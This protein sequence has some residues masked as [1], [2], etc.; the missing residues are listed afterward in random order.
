[1]RNM[2]RHL[3][4][5]AAAV[6]LA[7]PAAAYAD[8]GTETVVVTGMRAESEA[9]GIY[10]VK[11]ADH[12]ITNVT[13]VC[14]TRDA[15]QRKR[16]LKETL[17]GMMR[18]AAGSATISL[19]IG[20]RMV[21]K[22]AESDLDDVI[23]AESRADTSAAHIV[24]KTTVSATDTINGAIA[25]VMEF[26]AKTTRVGRTEVFRTSDW[27]LGLLGPEQYRDT[28][29]AKIVDDAKRVSAQFGPGYGVSIEG[30]ERPV[31]WVQKGP[32]DL[33]LFISY[34]LKIAPVEKAG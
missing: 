8:A 20:D 24:I 15:D 9:P 30:L 33:A 26:L 12:L 2:Q 14:D 10:I 17:R 23:A 16:E 21:D 3:M 1:M 4:S 28:I 11:R 19:G 27:E 32:L 13:A 22:L 6:L 29:L 34:S 25:R 7:L 18:A 31:Q 5:V